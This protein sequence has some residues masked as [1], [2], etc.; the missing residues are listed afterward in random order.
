MSD[1]DDGFETAFQRKTTNAAHMEWR[2]EDVTE[3]CGCVFCDLEL[4]PVF[5]IDGRL[6]HT[7]PKRGIG[8][9]FCTCDEPLPSASSE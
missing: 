2:P 9:S 8:Y 5:N 4:T 1:E 3:S 7:H 6:V